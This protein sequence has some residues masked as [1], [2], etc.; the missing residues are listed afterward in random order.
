MQRVDN[1]NKSGTIKKK[2]ATITIAT[3]APKRKNGI[4]HIE[5]VSTNLFNRESDSSLS[6]SDSEASA[7]LLPCSSSSRHPV[8]SNKNKD[9]S[10]DVVEIAAPSVQDPLKDAYLEDVL[11]STTEQK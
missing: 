8:T 11:I 10:P 7:P 6:Q 1:R 9:T 2:S 5:T 3:M 4:L